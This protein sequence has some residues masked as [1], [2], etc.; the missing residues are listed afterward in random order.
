MIQLS[1]GAR[2]PQ[3]FN[4][5]II[6]LQIKVVYV[7][8]ISRILASFPIAR[9]EPSHHLSSTVPTWNLLCSFAISYKFKGRDPD[10]CTDQHLPFYD[11]GSEVGPIRTQELHADRVHDQT[12]KTQL[13]TP[14]TQHFDSKSEGC[15]DIAN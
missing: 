14:R 9:T 15:L 2:L 11:S 6:D 5:N 8:L 1:E 3:D 10:G 13:E 4:L 12:L 7:N